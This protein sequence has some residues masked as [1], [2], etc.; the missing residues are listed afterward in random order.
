[1]ARKDAGKEVGEGER[2]ERLLDRDDAD[3]QTLRSGAACS[4]ACHDGHDGD[5]ELPHDHEAR[6]QRGARASASR[7]GSQER[8]E[9]QQG[10][11]LEVVDIGQV[12]AQLHE[13]RDEA[14]VF[15]LDGLLRVALEERRV[16]GR[17]RCERVPH[18][19]A[20]RGQQ[21]EHAR[22]GGEQHPHEAPPV[23]CA[24]DDRR[25]DR[26]RRDRRGGLQRDEGSDGEPGQREEAPVGEAT[27]AQ[28]R[29][30]G[31]AHR[32]R[33]G[34]ERQHVGREQAQRHRDHRQPRR[35][36]PDRLGPVP[37]EP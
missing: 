10:E 23:A 35:G 3:E 21:K 28:R 8:S 33:D 18:R 36:A 7:D 15:E 34:P 26:E 11:Q 32:D 24:E 27:T 29:R 17:G 20:V 37:R 25:H 16:H 31:H 14:P 12:S 9:G 4:G 30:Q 22:N 5:R 13:Q 1:M 2:H 19:R 6:E